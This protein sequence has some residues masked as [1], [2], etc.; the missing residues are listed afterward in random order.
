M[1]S[2]E[3]RCEFIYL[4]VTQLKGGHRGSRF[5]GAGISNPLAE[6]FRRV[7]RR[8]GSDRISAHQVR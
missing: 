3:V 1:K 4:P 2:L 6:I 8:P 5:D 7:E